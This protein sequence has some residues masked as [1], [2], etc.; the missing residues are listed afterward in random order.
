M[1][2]F[3][4]DKVPLILHWCPFFA[5]ALHLLPANAKEKPRQPPSPH[6]QLQS[7]PVSSSKAARQ[8]HVNDTD[9]NDSDCQPE[10]D[11]GRHPGLHRVLFALAFCQ[12]DLV[13]TGQDVTV[14]SQRASH[15]GWC[16]IDCVKWAWLFGLTR[17]ATQ[18]AVMP[19][20]YNLPVCSRLLV[21]MHASLILVLA[22][23]EESS[24]LLSADLGADA[25][26]IV[27]TPTFS[28]AEIRAMLPPAPPPPPPKDPEVCM[29]APRLLKYPIQP[30]TQ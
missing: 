20:H 13:S 11:S 26:Y 28:N 17:G 25:T 21:R 24:H 19:F 15:G 16:I 1:F 6:S 27:Q 8:Q 22:G 10:A 7:P 12:S 4:P 5:Q 23:K 14:T 30:D 9:V 29:K 3:L 18:C 2:I